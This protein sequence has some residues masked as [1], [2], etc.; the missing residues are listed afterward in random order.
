GQTTYGSDGYV[1]FVTNQANNFAG[2]QQSPFQY[3]TSDFGDAFAASND[4]GTTVYLGTAG[5]PDAYEDGLAPYIS[6]LSA[7]SDFFETVASNS[8][9][10]DGDDPRLPSDT[11]VA[12]TDLGIVVGPTNQVAGSEN[13]L[14]SFTVGA[15]SPSAFRLGVAYGTANDFLTPTA[16][17]V[18]ESSGIGTLTQSGLAPSGSEVNW[19]FF[20]I[21]NAETGDM[22]DIFATVRDRDSST[23]NRTAISAITFD[24]L[25]TVIPEPQT[26]A[27]GLLGA[28]GVALVLYRRGRG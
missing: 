18:T 17:R 10:A 19:A 24:S 8:I 7:G 1:F 12:D 11:N 6:Q 25:P 23:N 9:Y 3:V 15:N 27:L 2:N 14:V 26:Y 13:H 4:K 5:S 20:D 21:L 16:I 28:L 22:F